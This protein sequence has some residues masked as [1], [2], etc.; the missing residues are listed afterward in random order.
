MVVKAFWFLENM[1]WVLSEDGWVLS[2]D[3]WLLSEDGWLLS[4]DGWFVTL[5]F[6]VE[7]KGGFA[8][9]CPLADPGASLPRYRSANE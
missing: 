1:V 2:E 3:G 6:F 5:L 4:E 8:S 7:A 9:L